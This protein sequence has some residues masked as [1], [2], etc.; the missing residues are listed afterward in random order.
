MGILVSQPFRII[1]LRSRE[2]D[3]A[4]ESCGWLEHGRLGCGALWLLV[5]QSH[6]DYL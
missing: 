4:P 5:A 1:S 6:T 3:G 2:M